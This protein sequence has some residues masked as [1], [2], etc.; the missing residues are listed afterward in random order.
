VPVPKAAGRKKAKRLKDDDHT[1]HGLKASREEFFEKTYRGF[2]LKDKWVTPEQRASYETNLTWGKVL[3]EELAH[4]DSHTYVTHP[5]TGIVLRVFPRSRAMK[6]AKEQG[7]AWA[8]ART[9]TKRTAAEKKRLDEQKREREPADAPSG[10][11][12]KLRQWLKRPS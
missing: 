11:R 6:I 5:D 12:S 10:M 3:K 8:G 4:E 2:D 7:H 9:K 1:V